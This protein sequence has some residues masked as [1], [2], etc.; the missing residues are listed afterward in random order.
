MILYVFI[1][2][3]VLLILP[4]QRRLAVL[5]IATNIS[6]WYRKMCSCF[7]LD[8]SYLLLYSDEWGAIFT[9]PLVNKAEV[10][11]TSFTQLC[12]YIYM[13]IVYIFMN[14]YELCT[15]PTSTPPKSG[16]L[17]A[18]QRSWPEW[19]LKWDAV[20]RKLTMLTIPSLSQG[21]DNFD[22]FLSFEDDPTLADPLVQ[23]EWSWSTCSW[24]RSLGTWW[25]WWWG[26][27]IG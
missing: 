3:Y 4:A 10:Q 2:I 15:L 22:R 8:Y 1:N 7:A 6:F 5:I 27:G 25:W 17:T 14:L 20:P 9:K 11:L 16:W 26:G 12:I 21:I 19:I 24:E 13:H 23:V 18:S